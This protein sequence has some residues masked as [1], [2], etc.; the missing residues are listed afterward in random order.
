MGSLAI[1]YVCETNQINFCSRSDFDTDAHNS[2]DRFLCSFYFPS[3]GRLDDLG[4]LNEQPATQNLLLVGLFA[5]RVAGSFGLVGDVVAR[6]SEGVH[7][8]W[9]FLC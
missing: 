9:G 3:L 7:F 8:V 5:C 2:D 4:D 6:V 1:L